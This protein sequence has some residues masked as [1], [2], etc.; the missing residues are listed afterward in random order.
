MY[1][2]KQSLL[3]N[4]TGKRVNARYTLDILLPG[5]FF[6]PASLFFSAFTN[7]DFHSHDR[8]KISLLKHFV[9]RF[10]LKIFAVLPQN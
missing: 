9:R 6:N 4:K 8:R 5:A 10:R 2:I 3:R 7:L 1:I